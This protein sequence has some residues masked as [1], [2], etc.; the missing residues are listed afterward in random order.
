MMSQKLPIQLHNFKKQAGSSLLEVL[1]TVIITAIGLLGLALL[2]N[3][4]LRASYDSYARTQGGFL[5]ADLADRVR[6][7]PSV[8]YAL[9]TNPSEPD[10][11]AEGAECTPAQIRDF[12]LFHWQENAQ[13]VLPD[14]STEITSTFDAGTN[15]TLYTVTLSWEDRIENDATN[16]DPVEFD[17]HF[18][19]SNITP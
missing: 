18:R 8:N 17:Y 1:V 3:T 4:G 13:E 9:T 11:F 19:I 5:S 15:S 10:C 6:A 7:N 16:T 14:A 12:D 2:Q